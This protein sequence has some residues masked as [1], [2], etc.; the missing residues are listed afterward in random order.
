MSSAYSRQKLKTLCYVR[1]CIIKADLY[2]KDFLT[3]LVHE[4]MSLALANQMYD[5]VYPDLHA[6]NNPKSK[7]M[8]LIY[9]D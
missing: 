6:Q 8:H 9:F 1:Q 3:F 4:R 7:S 2:N 5:F